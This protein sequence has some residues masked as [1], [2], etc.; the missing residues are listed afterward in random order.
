MNMELKTEKFIRSFIREVLMEEKR[1]SRSCGIV[2][3]KKFGEKWKP[4]AL[5]LG[6]KF[7][8]PKGRMEKG[9][10][11]LE[12]AIRETE[13]ES[14]ISQL[15]FLWGKESFNFSN[16]TV[17]VAATLQEPKIRPNPETGR[18]EHDFSK[19]MDWD[20]MIHRS[21]P[22]ISNSLRWARRKIQQ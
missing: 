2:V 16:L 9:E 7:D 13:E 4:L 11:S 14:G 17:Y 15:N 20:D 3:V 5:V 10:N 6:R 19:W 8:I 22:K 18:R 1:L 21:S 12:T